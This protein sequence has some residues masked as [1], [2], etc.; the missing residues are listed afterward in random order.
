MSKK[1]YSRPAVEVVI[2]SRPGIQRESLVA[3]LSTLPSVEVTGLRDDVSALKKHPVPHQPN[4]LLL[5]VGYLDRHVAEISKQVKEIS[6][7]TKVMVL[8]GGIRAA[9]NT[10]GKEF[11][12]VIFNNVS[13]GEFLNSF[14]SLMESSINR[15]TP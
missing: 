8:V 3:L 9:R 7:R 6:P 12:R 13:T 4:I 10:R 11:D 15:K 2:V 5:D 1:R 14:Q